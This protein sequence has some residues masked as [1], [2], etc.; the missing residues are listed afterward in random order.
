MAAPCTAPGLVRVP[1]RVAAAVPIGATCRARASP[2]KDAAA[3]CISPCAD[4]PACARWRGD[5]APYAALPIAVARA[6]PNT[7]RAH[8]RGADAVPPAT[9]LTA[10]NFT[11]ARQRGVVAAPCPAPYAHAPARADAECRC[12]SRALAPRSLASRAASRPRSAPPSRRIPP[13][14]SR[15]RNAPP[16][17]GSMRRLRSVPRRPRSAL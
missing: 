16:P 14:G 12:P 3:P 6:A 11:R 4:A 17:R 1:Q 8:Q 15:T 9:A 2:R 7:T 5:V 13:R 10:F